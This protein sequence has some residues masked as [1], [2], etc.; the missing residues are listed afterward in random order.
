MK[1]AI[2]ILS[3][4]AKNI[5][6]SIKS[7]FMESID[8]LEEE[9]FMESNES[10][11]REHERII[12]SGNLSL[13]KAVCEACIREDKPLYIVPTADQRFFNRAF[14]LPDDHEQALRQALEEESYPVDILRCN[15]QIVL[16]S[17]VIA[18]VPV[19]SKRVYEIPMGMIERLRLF[20]GQLGRIRA[21]TLHSFNITTKKGQEIRTAASGLYLFEHDNKT[22]SKNLLNDTTTAMDGKLSAVLL[23][24]QSALDYIAFL[25]RLV[26]SRTKSFTRLPRSVGYL[27]SSELTVSSD[28]PYPVLVDKEVTLETP[29]TLRVD[30]KALRLIAGKSFAEAN[31]IPV[32]DKESI[33]VEHLPDEKERSVQVERKLPFFPSAS[34]ERYKTL[35]LSLREDAGPTPEYLTLMVLST[36]LAAL[37][38]FLNSASVVIG[39]MILAPLMAPIVSF[40][41][42]VLRKDSPLFYR[43]LS[44][45][46][47]G[48][49]IAVTASALL[50]S[51]MPIHIWT[52]ELKGRLQPSLL[53]LMVAVLSGIAAAFAKADIKISQSL[54]G[55][56]IAVA[57]VPPLAVVGIGIGWMDGFIITNALLLFVTNLVGIVLAATLT[58]LVLGYSADVKGKRSF[59]ALWLLTALITVPLY[60]TFDKIERY[61]AVRTTLNDKQLKIE[62]AKI[63]ITNVRVIPGSGD[64]NIRCDIVSDT[65]LDEAHIRIL[66]K[67]ME[68]SLGEPLLLEA[69]FIRRY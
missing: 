18:D 61:A 25:G 53:D 2:A 41:M 34:E 24:P 20:L 51:L 28:R 5:E 33:R 13:I 62:G 9:R 11:I 65:A 59:W 50:T 17:A 46:A 36:M 3:S 48:I 52:D 15:E 44:T 32:D 4:E 54:A 63:T 55:V 7:L 37:G 47:V 26:L 64:L 21:I 10:L 40:S 29:V 66:K 60:F 14:F 43:S 49:G 42:G 35:F 57:L 39:A 30:H 27:K 23:S 16:N 68:R 1:P 38:I 69:S 58:F 19:I 8:L 45:M 12:V 31:D 6:A 67:I 56:A 22:V